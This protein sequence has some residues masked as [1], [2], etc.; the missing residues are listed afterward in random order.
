VRPT[1]PTS[2]NLC[3]RL[4]NPIFSSCLKIWSY[5]F[6]NAN[7]CSKQASFQKTITS[8]YQWW[9]ITERNGRNHFSFQEVFILKYSEDFRL[10]KGAVKSILLLNYYSHSLLMKLN[11]SSQKYTISET[12]HMRIVSFFLFCACRL[13]QWLHIWGSSC[14]MFFFLPLLRLPCISV[15]VLQ[16]IYTFPIFTRSVREEHN[17]NGNLRP[18]FLD[19]HPVRAVW[20]Q[21]KGLSPHLASG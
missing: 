18:Q 2:C 10:L 6:N 4:T 8:N 16:F 12:P 20:R 13:F 14:F 3:Q 1:A 19:L 9:F 15:T 17:P 11:R 5:P 7:K 21:G